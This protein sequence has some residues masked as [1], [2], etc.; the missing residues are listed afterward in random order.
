MS[1]EVLKGEYM[2]PRDMNGHGT[3]VASTIAG[4]QVRNA[5][6]VGLGVGARLAVYKA[7]W[8]SGKCGATA[9]LAAIDDAINNGVDVLS[10]SLTLDSE[11][12]GTLHTVAKGVTV[13]F[14]AGNKVWGAWIRGSHIDETHWRRRRK[15]TPGPRRQTPGALPPGQ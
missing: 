10:L 8:G 5:S 15:W 11:V 12:P 13:V 14:S 9:V 6:Y 3:H 4:G 7:C 2:S 1:A